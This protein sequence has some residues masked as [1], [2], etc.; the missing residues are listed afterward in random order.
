[1]FGLTALFLLFFVPGMTF[2]AAGVLL[3]RPKRWKFEIQRQRRQ[4]LAVTL[5][6][7]LASA[8]GAAALLLAMHNNNA[9][10]VARVLA[11][12]PF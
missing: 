2:V 5:L 12:A 1:M 9:C 4:L 8:A 6:L 10:E 7:A 11:W 3:Q